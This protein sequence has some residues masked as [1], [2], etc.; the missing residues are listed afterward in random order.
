MGKKY[1]F[2]VPGCGCCP[3]QQAAGSSIYGTRY[4]AGFKHRKPKRFRRSDPVSK[5]P[6]WCPKRITPPACRVY[7]FK[8]EQSE[9]MD[10]LWREEYRSGR[11]KTISPSSFHYQFRAEIRLGMTARQFFDAVQ[12]SPLYDV[13][14]EEVHSGEVIEIDDGLQA[15]CFYVLDSDTVIPLPYFRLPPASRE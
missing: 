3:H 6:K 2:P 8:D 12:E 1:T 4:C 5:A 7:G 11:T 10:F 9:H 15:Y 14:P 13:L